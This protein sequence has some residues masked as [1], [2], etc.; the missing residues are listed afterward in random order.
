MAFVALAAVAVT[1]LAGAYASYKKGEISREEYEKQKALVAGIQA[2]LEAPPGTAQKFTPEEYTYAKKYTPEIA[3][4]VEEKQPTVVNE[5]RSQRE[6]GMQQDALGQYQNLA[7]T[8]VDK[9]SDAQREEA[10]F[11]ADARD[12]SRRASIMRDQANRGLTGS[13]TDILMQQQSSQDAAVGARQASLDAT[14]QAEARRMA[15][16]GNMSSLAGQVRGQNA[17]TEN[18]NAQ[19]MNSFNQRL[20]NSKNLYNAQT[21]NANNEAQRFNI[22][23]EHATDNAN[24][25]L[26]NNA[27]YA[28]MT[29]QEA[30]ERERRDFQN[31]AASGQFDK[32]SGLNKMQADN[33]RTQ[34]AD[35][36]QTASS[37]FAAGSSSYG[38]GQAADRDDA[39]AAR[40]TRAL[41]QKDH[42]L[43]IDTKP[44]SNSTNQSNLTEEP[45]AQ[46]PRRSRSLF[47]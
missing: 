15:A 14:R 38:A 45:V 36:A 6:I 3:T 43:G 17:S 33:Q 46:G 13:G 25:A 2:K 11:D 8:G 41:D 32:L 39:R 5:A 30:A 42:E 37:A 29:R 19:I 10:L 22:S 44:L 40:E 47:A 12:K 16:L 27:A 35:Y 9:V 21:A 18:I 26:R 7:R 31:N 1:A 28:N 23:N 34:A 20:A 4:F 24:T